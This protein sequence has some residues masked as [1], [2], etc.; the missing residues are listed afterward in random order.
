MAAIPPKTN[1]DGLKV[2]VLSALDGAFIRGKKAGRYEQQQ[3]YL[4][5]RAEH[6]RAKRERDALMADLTQV[7]GG[8][9][10][11]TCLVCSHYRT[12]WEKPGCELNGLA[13]IWSWRGVQK[14]DQDR[15]N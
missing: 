5:K 9:T 2:S 12:D 8:E 6:E 15:E 1:I 7:C 4:E 10:I 11:N 3:E 13:C 14:N